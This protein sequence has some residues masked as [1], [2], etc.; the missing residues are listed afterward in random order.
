MRPD[1]NL[2]GKTGGSSAY[3]I[4]ACL[5]RLLRPTGA[6]RTSA[7]DN[8]HFRR[9]C[10]ADSIAHSDSAAK[11]HPRPNDSPPANLSYQ[12]D[13]AP[14]IPI[15]AYTCPQAHAWFGEHRGGHRPTG[16]HIRDR[17]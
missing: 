6:H 4:A 12:V 2:R 16:S 5:G 8:A 7:G 9:D 14:C 17:P 3:D 13:A 10:H 15:N 11:Y 1:G